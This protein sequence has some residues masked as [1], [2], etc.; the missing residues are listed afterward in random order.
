MKIST[1]RVTPS[2]EPGF[3]RELVPKEPPVQGEE[4]E[5]IFQDFESKIMPGVT[6]FFVIYFF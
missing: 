6:N 2:V 1:R 4:W 3:L 5:K